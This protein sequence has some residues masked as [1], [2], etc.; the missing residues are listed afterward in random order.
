MDFFTDASLNGEKQVAGIGC[1]CVDDRSDETSE[2]ASFFK[3]DNIHF[4]E[5]YALAFAVQKAASLG[6]RNARIVSDSVSALNT[7][8][9][10]VDA[11]T[12]VRSRNMT[13][14]QKQFL[15]NIDA[16]PVQKTALDNIVNTFMTSGISFKFVHVNGHLK[17]AKVGS[18]GYWNK[19]ADR[20]AKNA[21]ILGENAFENGIVHQPDE[22]LTN[23]SA[24]P[25]LD[26]WRDRIQV[27]YVHAKQKDK[28]LPKKVAR[29]R[30]SNED[31]Y[32]I[33]IMVNLRIKMR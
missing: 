3:M 15:R 19:R 30:K 7:L 25:T 33:R 16:S 5:L 2:F 1:V 14:E 32:N 31:T 21:R 24:L 29:H 23:Y 11:I 20:A 10:Y 13:A 17:S 8:H 4:A 18:D 27:P 26:D 28:N 6:V 22:I 9:W 12:N